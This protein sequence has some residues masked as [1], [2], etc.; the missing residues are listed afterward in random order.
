MFKPTKQQ[1]KI[2]DCNDN[3]VVYAGPGSGKTST[4]AHKIC[5]VIDGLYWYQGVAAI[6]YTNKASGEL[7]DKTKSLCSD[8]KNSFFSTIDSFYIGNI[9]I[10]FGKRYFGIPQ[11]QL[12]VEN[13]DEYYNSLI[14]NI[15][16]EI[17]GILLRYKEYSIKQLE[18]ENINLINQLSM[19]TIDFIKK[20]FG[21]GVFDLRLVGSVSN[22]IFLSSKA[23][24]NYFKSRYKFVFIDE[25]QDSGEYQYNLFLRISEI[26]VKCWAIGDI[27]QSIF[28]FANKDAKYLKR[29][30]SNQ[31][32]KKFPMTINH[33]CHP[34]INVYS[35]KLLGFEETPIK[36]DNRVFDVYVDGTESDIGVWF[37]DNLALI[38][39][40]LEINHNSQIGILA[41]KNITLEK[42]IETIDIPH[43]L[44]N[45]TILD[46]DRSLCSGLLNDLLTMAF[47]NKQTIFSF[48]DSYLDREV[49]NQ[50]YRI[51]KVSQLIKEFK[52]NIVDAFKGFNDNA[53]E[54]IMIFKDISA[55]FYPEIDNQRAILN[56]KFLLE[57]KKRLADFLPA[58]DNEIQL[59]N[60][61]KSKGLEFEV[62][63]HLDLY[64]FLL[65]EFDWIKYQDYDSYSDSLN[66]HYVGVTR[67]KKAIFLMS[68]SHR[69][70]SSNDR[71]IQAQKSEFLTELKDFQS[72]W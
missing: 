66:L 12:S 37:K 51:K 28:R 44:Y 36:N 2:L 20:N 46:D 34:S 7:K 25:F 48:V 57:N 32:F 58:Q 4:I 62:V 59:M 64:Q 68:S 27:N 19:G 61:Y 42:F 41:K 39:E 9:I 6:S 50:R 10:P 47:N 65:P 14:E 15:L 60:L 70:Q 24:R 33:R 56:L 38:K 67:A 49:M 69:Y 63:I 5:S 17:E 3:C 23:C 29:L 31:N 43:K 54:L 16:S 8:L 53:E 30:L 26:G 52:K 40:R 1:E 22:L 35:R 72:N 11:K 55:C 71:F 21:E 13:L 18:D 45:K